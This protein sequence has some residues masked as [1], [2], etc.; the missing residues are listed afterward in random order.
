MKKTVSI[1]CAML[2]LTACSDGKQ[3]ITRLVERNGLMYQQNSN[4]PFTGTFTEY[5]VY[6]QDRKR[7][8]TSYKN[9][10]KDGL[11]ILWSQTGQI[12]SQANFKDGVQNGTETIWYLNGVKGGEGE[13]ADGKKHGPWTEWYTNGRKWKQGSYLN[14]A[15]DGVWTEWSEDGGSTTRTTYRNGKPVKS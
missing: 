15:K 11:Y 14:G 3:E 12:A 6:G 10:K 4:T 9:G 1:L 5:S 7:A 2:F 8:E 13:F